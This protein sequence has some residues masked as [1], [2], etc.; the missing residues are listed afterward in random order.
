MLTG[1]MTKHSWFTIFTCIKKDS[2]YLYFVVFNW[3]CMAG[4]GFNMYRIGHTTIPNFTEPDENTTH[5]IL[6]NQ[7]CFNYEYVWFFQ[8]N[9][10]NTVLQ[11]Q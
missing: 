3:I 10:S 1:T 8:E 7:L 9:I 5:F 2:C 4:I 6:K 11:F